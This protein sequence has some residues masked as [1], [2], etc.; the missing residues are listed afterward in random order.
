M[1]RATQ[2][3][4]AGGCAAPDRRRGFAASGLP[5]DHRAAAKPRRRPAAKPT[6]AVIAPDARS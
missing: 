1:L 2:A 4:L 5:A 3:S 6:P